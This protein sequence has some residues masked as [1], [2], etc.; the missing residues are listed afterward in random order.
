LLTVYPINTGIYRMVL[1]FDE[2]IKFSSSWTEGRNQH[3]NPPKLLEASAHIRTEA[4]PIYYGE[5][6]FIANLEDDFLGALESCEW[7]SALWRSAGPFRC[8]LK[9]VEI[10][11]QSKMLLRVRVPTGRLDVWALKL[12]KHV[13]RDGPDYA[14]PLRD[15]FSALIE[16]ELEDPFET[17]L[18]LTTSSEM[19]ELVRWARKEAGFKRRLKC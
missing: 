2:P 15:G 3:F 16:R 11:I 1:V 6:T 18:R 13:K 19:M 7:I 10:S 8:E 4:A 9:R 14:G 17:I 12:G 5:N